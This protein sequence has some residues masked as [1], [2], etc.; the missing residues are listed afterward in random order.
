M[1]VDE[2]QPAVPQQ[3]DGTLLQP[4][5]LDE[6]DQLIV[7]ALQLSPRA[8]WARIADALEISESTVLRRGERLLS[9]RRIRVSAL[10]DP[11]RCGLGFPVVVRL[12][13]EVGS[14]HSVAHELALRPDARLVVVVA[15]S[16]DVL[17]EF[18]VQ[19]RAHL[20][21]VLCEGL[22]TIPG[23]VR[24]ESATV[25]RTFKTSYDWGRSILGQ[26]A[27]ALEHADDSPETFPK[28][29]LDDADQRLV[30]LLSIEGRL[31]VKEIAS[32]AGM[33]ESSARRRVDAL[34]KSRMIQF[35]TFV[36]PS[37]LGFEAPL[38]IWFHVDAEHLDSVARQLADL[39]AVRYVAATTGEYQL[40]A[41]I[42]LKNI[43]QIYDFITSKI[44]ALEHVRRTEVGLEL[45]TLKRGYFPQSGYGDDNGDRRPST[46]DREA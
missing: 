16:Y 35:G 12:T 31:K 44:T 43:D 45:S 8:S 17:V 39:T 33:S 15:S 21:V 13:C 24:S 26:A 29:R 22:K 20:E 42:I 19:S 36:E 27:S 30:D 38:F 46:V 2:G 32:R 14:S 4:D 10:P 9:T 23:I 41:E 25:I 37:R 3:A 34:W 5:V 18:V 1:S 11:L 40:I 6:V 28:R 7:A